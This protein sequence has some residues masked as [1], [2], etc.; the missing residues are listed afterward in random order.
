M[1]ANQLSFLLILTRC[2]GD[3]RPPSLNPEEFTNAPM[4]ETFTG[5]TGSALPR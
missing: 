3:N 2:C 1:L 4:N 5:A